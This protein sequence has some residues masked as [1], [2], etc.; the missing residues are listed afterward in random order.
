MSE[1]QQTNFNSPLGLL[2]PAVGQIGLWALAAQQPVAAADS[3]NTVNGGG[4]IE[5]DELNHRTSSTLL[6]FA[7]VKNKNR[8]KQHCQYHAKGVLKS[9]MPLQ[10]PRLLRQGAGRLQTVGEHVTVNT[11]RFE[12]SYALA[13]T[14]HGYCHLSASTTQATRHVAL[15]DDVMAGQAWRQWQQEHWHGV[16][17]C[18]AHK[19]AAPAWTANK[20]WCTRHWFSLYPQQAHPPA[21][22]SPSTTCAEVHCVCLYQQARHT[23]RQ[24][25]KSTNPQ[26]QDRSSPGTSRNPIMIH[27]HCRCRC[28]ASTHIHTP[29]CWNMD[30]TK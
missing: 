23:A 24:T 16:Q 18:Y 29:S 30:S 9:L 17:Q 1:P 21:Q 27:I 6:V 14:N 10:W 19:E 28:T 20:H 8:H 7:L 22:S 15:N 25:G 3:D 12:K 5:Q 26:A 13:A 11:K 4:W 2:A